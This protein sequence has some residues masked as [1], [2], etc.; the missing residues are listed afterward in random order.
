MF[1]KLWYLGQVDR[2]WS[3]ILLKA[4]TGYGCS[5]FRTYPIKR[6]PSEGGLVKVGRG[7]LKWVKGQSVG[8]RIRVRVVS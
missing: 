8:M 2:R 7:L 4:K 5:L 6:N 1:A 3:G